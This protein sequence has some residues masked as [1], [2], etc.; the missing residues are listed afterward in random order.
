MLLLPAGA[1][2]SFRVL[3]GTEG[4]HS[5]FCFVFFVRLSIIIIFFVLFFVD[6]FSCRCCAI[7]EF[8]PNVTDTSHAPSPLQ[9]PPHCWFFV[10]F[11]FVFFC[12]GSFL[13]LR[14]VNSSSALSGGTPLMC[15]TRPPSSCQN[16]SNRARRPTD[17]PSVGFKF[18]LSRPFFLSSLP[19]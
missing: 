16:I 11:F 7:A 15:H 19:Q 17:Y 4:A 10:F 9:P 8:A 12:S 1:E 13:P 2:K 6:F 5:A 18:C 14:R 3:T